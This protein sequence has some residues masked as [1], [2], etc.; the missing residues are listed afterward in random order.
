MKTFFTAT[1]LAV[2]VSASLSYFKYSRDV[3]GAAAGH[4]NYFVVDE[5]VWQ[6]ANPDLGDLRLYASDSTEVPYALTIQ[7][8]S[9]ETEQK[10][11]KVLQPGTVGDKTQFFLDMAGLTEYDRIA[12][13]LK[14][15]NFV[16]KVRVEGQ[17]DLHGEHW[18]TLIN[19]ILYDLSDDNL[20]GN[21][22]LR[23]PVTRYQYLRVT[24]DG[25]VKPSDIEGATANIR[26]EEK[27]VWRNISSEPKRE[28]KNKETVFT[29]A[30]PAN[31]PVEQVEFTID[32]TQPNFKREVEVQS[33]K[34]DWPSSTG[35]LA[36]VHIVR[37]G[38]KID[39][40]Q[41]SLDL[42]DIRP[43]SLKVII[44]NG[45][46]PPLKITNVRLKQY[47]RRV[48]FN[49]AQPP[50]LYYGDEKLDGPVYDYAKLFQQEANATEVKFGPEQTNT[51]YTGRPDER[52][53]SDKHPAVLWIAIGAAVLVLGAM[54]LR[55]M[56]SVA[57]T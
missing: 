46:D 34:N 21:S 29:F 20:G 24:L 38:Q 14:A 57:S 39:F 9:S 22:T 52:P 32:P 42:N 12:L 26:E 51:A 47:E 1:A 28:D 27:A 31:V 30:L 6:H 7:R 2:L 19:T 56:K 48:Y 13:K 8:G 44:H 55:S 4:Q 40:E 11:V 41:S 15:T 18:A 45:D 53:W 23:L 37:H 43:E 3:Q 35:E 50:H 49:A 25:P 16:T 33:G 36:R 10:D 17:D 5:T 54:A